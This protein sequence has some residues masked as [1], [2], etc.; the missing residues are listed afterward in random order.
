VRRIQEEIFPREKDDAP[1]LVC[2]I[3]VQGVRHGGKV[4]ETVR[5]P[6]LPQ[7]SGGFKERMTTTDDNI[8]TIAM[9]TK[10]LEMV[11]GGAM[12]HLGGMGKL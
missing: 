9:T 8:A 11:E 7:S 12:R 6:A 5:V 2:R 10:K 3:E 1:G 4:G